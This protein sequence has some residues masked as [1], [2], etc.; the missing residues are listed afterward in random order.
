MYIYT[1]EMFQL[2]S[3]I[4]SDTTI[5][6]RNRWKDL[7]SCQI[8]WPHWR[9][10]NG[11]S[12]RPNEFLGYSYDNKDNDSRGGERWLAGERE[13]KGIATLVIIPSL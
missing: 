11:I 8:L 7:E 9:G 10:K 4:P 6:E 2:S 13:K 1:R 12:G 3:D 5:V